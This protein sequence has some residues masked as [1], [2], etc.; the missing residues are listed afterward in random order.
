MVSPEIL[1]YT[2]ES[3]NHYDSRYKRLID[4]VKQFFE[5]GLIKSKTSERLKA[6]VEPVR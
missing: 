1:K 6:T 2:V 4:A 3:D 5:S